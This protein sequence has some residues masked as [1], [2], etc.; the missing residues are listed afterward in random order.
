M[1][2]S[3]G[4]RRY[5]SRRRLGW[6]C[7]RSSHCAVGA[8]TKCGAFHLNSRP[9]ACLADSHLLHSSVSNVLIQTLCQWLWIQQLYCHA[10]QVSLDH[11]RTVH[12]STRQRT[13]Q[14]EFP[15]T[16]ARHVQSISGSHEVLLNNPYFCNCRFKPLRTAVTDAVFLSPALL[17]PRRVPAGAAIAQFFS[18]C[19]ENLSPI[20]FEA[21]RT[22]IAPRSMSG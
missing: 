10:W 17:S 2:W 3:A 16:I 6:Q 14:R 15:P 19:I 20:Q 11:G 7:A 22:H 4:S 13:F 9:T 21:R 5:S 18:K 12:P 1:P 8:V